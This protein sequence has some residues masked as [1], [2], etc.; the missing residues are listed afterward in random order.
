MNI[1]SF[2]TVALFVGASS[3]SAWRTQSRRSPR[4]LWGAMAVAALAFA[5]AV[6][7]AFGPVAQD[8]PERLAYPPPFE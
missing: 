4:L 2:I 3:S 6:G 1:G 7:W 5:A 8:L